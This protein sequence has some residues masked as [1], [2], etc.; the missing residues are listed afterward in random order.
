MSRRFEKALADLIEAK[1]TRG[2]LVQLLSGL[3]GGRR[4]VAAL[5]GA[6]VS[7]DTTSG[8][9]AALLCKRRVDGAFLDALTAMQP[10]NAADIEL[11][12]GLRRASRLGWVVAGGLVVVG[13][14]VVAVL[15]TNPSRLTDKITATIEDGCNVCVRRDDI[16]SLCENAASAILMLHGAN[17][18]PGINAMES[19]DPL[20]VRWGNE[21]LR[22]VFTAD[23]RCSAGATEV[24]RHTG[25]RC[26]QRGSIV[27]ER[28]RP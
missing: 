23:L 5:P 13:G 14:A 4:L 26:S 17:Q 25:L 28:G 22:S 9:A 15:V 10:H 7:W 19:V 3:T 11:A 16:G 2:E 8:E 1:L 24:F 12:R 18:K 20:C 21:A 6:V 27:L